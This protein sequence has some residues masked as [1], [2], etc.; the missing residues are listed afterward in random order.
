[1]AENITLIKSG[2]T[3]NGDVSAKIKENIKCVKKYF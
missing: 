1:M 2:I 3:I